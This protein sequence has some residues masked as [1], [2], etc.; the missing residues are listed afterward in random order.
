[1]KYIIV[2]FISYN[3]SDQRIGRMLHEFWLSRLDK[4]PVDNFIFVGDHMDFK[5][6]V[7]N[8]K[9]KTVHYIN[10][11][12]EGSH[13]NNIHKALNKLNDNDKFIILD[14]DLMIYDHNFI[15]NIFE[16]LN[17][18]DIVS[19]I[20]GG[21][22]IQITPESD[23]AKHDLG[24]D[25]YRNFTLS[26]P[27]FNFNEYRNSRCRFAATIFG[28]KKSFWEKHQDYSSQIMPETSEESYE[29]MELF[30]RKVIEIS[31]NVKVKELLDYRFN[32]VYTIDNKVFDKYPNT[33][34]TR[35]TEEATR[36][37]SYYHIRNFGETP[38]IIGQYQR[39]EKRDGRD[40]REVL[41]LTAWFI[42]V[43]E[44]LLENDNSFGDYS[45]YIN[46]IITDHCKITSQ[47]FND[48]LSRFKEFH[49]TNLL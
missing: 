30:S 26:L 29:S 20:D 4:F 35:C 7:V 49:R 2:P 48:Y 5:T 45:D 36:N 10:T 38:K 6:Q 43:Y 21:C 28:C 24:D 33:D 42:V 9:N 11:Q 39:N 40:K 8:I 27:I 47:E 34:D 3:L 44:K 31:P 19:N 37:A 1:M 23:Q 13:Q 22:K 41:R 46:K 25:P 12:N 18:Y 14:S 17:E 32:F 16:D 15:S